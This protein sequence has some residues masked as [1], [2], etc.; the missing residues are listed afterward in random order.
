MSTEAKNPNGPTPLRPVPLCHRLLAAP[1]SV[2]RS[3]VGS[4]CSMWA[5]VETGAQAGPSGFCF[6]VRAAGGY[7]PPWL[8][9]AQDAPE[10]A[11]MPAEAPVEPPLKSESHFDKAKGLAA[12]LGECTGTGLGAAS[13]S[14]GVKG[15]GY[16]VAVAVLPERVRA[17]MCLTRSWA[18]ADG[19]APTADEYWPGG[20]PVS[21]P[22]YDGWRPWALQAKPPVAGAT[23]VDLEL[24][25]GEFLFRRPANTI[26][27]GPPGPVDDSLEDIVKWRL[28]APAEA[29]TQARR[30]LRA[31][32]RELETT[33]IALAEA[34]AELER[35]GSTRAYEARWDFLP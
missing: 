16:Y 6:E 34:E 31:A 27:W 15:G 1:A 3:C 28:G 23:E 4:A 19:V 9:P 18:Q 10:P 12:A 21:E 35:L 30:E 26:R 7:M 20:V 11:A 5:L 24:R 22:C 17:L 14:F 13:Y 29:L 2:D 8:D 25:S 33:R 32:L